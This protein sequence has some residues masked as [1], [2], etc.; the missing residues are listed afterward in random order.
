MGF[1]R[2]VI[3]GLLRDPVSLVEAI[4]AW[5]ET[6]GNGRGPQDAYL[7]WRLFTA[8]GDDAA[9][10]GAQDLLDYLRWRR[11]MRAIRRSERP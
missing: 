9:T 10:F 3:A 4:R 6:R 7:R 1:E 5:R 8:Y 11:D 2:G